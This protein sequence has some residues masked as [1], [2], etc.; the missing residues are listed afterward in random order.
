MLG[1]DGRGKMSG[2]EAYTANTETPIRATK[3]GVGLRLIPGAMGVEA[4]G[5][6][7]NKDTSRPESV[8]A[9]HRLTSLSQHAACGEGEHQSQ[10]PGNWPNQMAK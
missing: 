4:V 2:F 3:Y 7:K 10:E 1:E 8:W 9:L 6:A 5:C